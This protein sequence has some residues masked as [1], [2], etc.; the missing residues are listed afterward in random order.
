MQGKLIAILLLFFYS[1]AHSS[2]SCK[3]SKLLSHD[4]LASNSKFWDELSKIKH[5]DSDLEKLIQKHSPALLKT[6][7]VPAV[8]TKSR[9]PFHVHK[10]AEHAFGNDKNSKQFKRYEEFLDIMTDPSRGL[11]SISN[12][13]AGAAV[14]DVKSGWNHKTLKENKNHHS[15]R[16]SDGSRILFEIRNGELHILDV[17][18]HV[19]H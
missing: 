18:K 1:T 9:L 6:S 17:G 16:L 4:S 7:D 3:L 5:T 19:T 2:F 13:R 14:T 8:V 11:N 15:V 10:T 12:S